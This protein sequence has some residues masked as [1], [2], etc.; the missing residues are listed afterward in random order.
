MPSLQT[1]DSHL[2]DKN[3]EEEKVPQWINDICEDCVAKL[4]QLNK[5]F[6]YC[7]ALAACLPV[8]SARPYLILF[9]S[10]LL[11]IALRTHIVTAVIMQRNGAAFH[12]NTSCFWDAT[13]DGACSFTHLRYCYSLSSDAMCC[14]CICYCCSRARSLSPFLPVACSRQACKSS[15]GRACA[16]I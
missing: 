5:P 4:V 2:K 3:Y 14:R 7:G 12:A 1:I 13:R 8:P 9:L 16:T 11:C 10:I 6:K 15:A